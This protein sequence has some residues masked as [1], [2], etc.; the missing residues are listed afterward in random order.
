[1]SID[2]V[3]VEKIENTE[4]D[5]PVLAADEVH[6]AVAPQQRMIA[7]KFAGTCLVCED[8]HSGHTGFIAVPAE[9]V[10]V[11]IEQMRAC[12]KRVAS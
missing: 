7:F 8:R 11:M 3:A 12:L 6:I 2:D 5:P 4:A 10:P 1:M 9:M